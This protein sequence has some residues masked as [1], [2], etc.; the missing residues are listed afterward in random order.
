[1]KSNSKGRTVM[2]RG[3]N[4][5]LLVKIGTG[6]L[7]LIA[8]GSSLILAQ[9]STAAISGI[10]RDATGALI[11]GATVSAK[12]IE[13]GLTRMAVSSE[14]GG[15]NL[16]LLPVGAYELSTDI[17]G[18]KQQVRRG[19]NLVV[20]QEAVSNLTLDVGAA[21]ELVTVT[22]EAPIVNTTLSSTSGLINEAQIKELPLNGRS[23]DQLLTLNVGT[24]DNRS[25]V[26]NNGWTAFSVAGKRPETN[27][28]LMN[29][30][31]Y[32]GS[33][34]AGSYITPSGSSGQLL[35]VEAVR[36]YNVLQ[37]T[38]GAEYG[39]RAGAQ[40]TVVS[41]SGT[42]QWHGDLFEYMRNS[43]LDARNPFENAKGPFQR[44]QFGGALG[45]PL[46]KDKA[47]L[48]GNYE[49]FRERWG[50]PSVAIVPDG[51][52]RQGRLPNAAGVFVPVANLEQRMLQYANTFWPAPTQE[53]FRDGLPTG[54]AY[55][56]SNP[57]RKVR[58]DFGLLRFDY[59]HSTK[60]SF[61]VNVNGDDG[62]RV[63]PQIDPI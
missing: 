16:Q 46:K 37:H 4:L 43:A 45:G 26:S 58:E 23:F 38:Y 3:R 13:S 44:N 19:S 39:K 51:D 34:G 33:N 57:K 59:T 22:D 6:I 52:A 14:N 11:P 50:V 35:G 29:G 41:S 24:V 7:G 28:F 12:H 9:G 53:I 54:S 32:I 31:D 56:A 21:A 55:A 30:V 48:F 2:V 27:R 18:F 40:V 36:E 47:F 49:G 60:D 25:N 20:G 17:P 62:S 10:V 61:Y 15:Y 1:M 63:N 5:H 42:N 8:L